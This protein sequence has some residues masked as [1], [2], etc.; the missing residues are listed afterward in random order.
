MGMFDDNKQ[1]LDREAIRTEVRKE[2][3]A[4]KQAAATRG[5]IA[6]PAPI[7]N[8]LDKFDPERHGGEAMAFAPVGR[9]FGSP[10]YEG[11]AAQDWAE[12]QSKI[13][14]LIDA[15]REMPEAMSSVVS[16]RELDGALNVQA[17][18]F[19]LGHDVGGGLAVAVWRHY[20]RS[21]MAEW[22]SGE[23]TVESAK[24]TLISYCKQLRI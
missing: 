3:L 10:E 20:S 7:V 11:L 14:K 18:L 13:S 23:E 6:N 4:L 8:L 21:L 22:L 9:E 24:H 1:L 12:V 15:C 2:L 19:E 16:P 17:A 5:S